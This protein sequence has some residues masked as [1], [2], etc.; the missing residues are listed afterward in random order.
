MVADRRLTEPERLGEVA[1][2]CFVARL[3]LDQAE[4]PEPRR[5][6]RSPSARPPAAR[7]PRPRAAPAGAARTRRRWSR[8]SAR[9]PYMTEIDVPVM[10]PTDIDRR[11]YRPEGSPCSEILDPVTRNHVRQAARQLSS[12]FA[13]I[14]SEADDRALHRRVGRP[15]RRLEVQRLRSG[16]CAPLRAPAAEGARAG[17]QPDRE[18]AARGAVRLRPQRRT[19]PDGGRARQAPRRGDGSTFARPAALPGARST[20]P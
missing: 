16:A 17:R 14:F 8:S 1:D 15:P 3:G 7:R 2:A 11:R 9:H 13:G 6:R 4:Q 18:G 10:M 19:K 5:D 20:R 12:E